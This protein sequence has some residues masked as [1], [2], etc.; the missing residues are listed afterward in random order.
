MR[1]GASLHVVHLNSAATRKTREALRMIEGARLRGLDVT[2][3]VYPYIAG[4]TRLE[5]AFFDTGWQERQE[6]TYSRSLAAGHR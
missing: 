1:A 4:A 3:E 6:I 5:S 2:T